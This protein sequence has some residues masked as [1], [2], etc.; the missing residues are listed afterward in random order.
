[1]QTYW[2]AQVEELSKNFRLLLMDH[3]GFGRSDS[4]EEFS[5]AG[6]AS[7]VVALLD[8]YSVPSADLVGLSP[9]EPSRYTLHSRGRIA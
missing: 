7:D 6:C 8:E 3:R 5:I 2:A 9:E 4:L 1:L